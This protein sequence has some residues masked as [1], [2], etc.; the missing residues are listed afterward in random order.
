VR[1]RWSE[2]TIASMKT[3]ALR[4]RSLLGDI[5]ITPVADALARAV[6]QHLDKRAL[7]IYRRTIE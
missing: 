3:S 7:T 4:L 6:D 2:L 1:W 5:S